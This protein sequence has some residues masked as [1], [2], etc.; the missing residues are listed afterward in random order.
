MAVLLPV[1]AVGGFMVKRWI[2]DRT[3]RESDSTRA[4]AE[5]AEQ[6]F[7]VAVVAGHGALAA[8]TFVLAVLAASGL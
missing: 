5:P 1:I 8:I 6:A 2:T 7:P 3:L 4:P